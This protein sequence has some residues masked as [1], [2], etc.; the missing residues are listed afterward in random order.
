[1][2]SYFQ[3]NSNVQIN[4]YVTDI[5]NKKIFLMDVSN[6][7]SWTE[8]KSFSKHRI[9]QTTLTSIIILIAQ[10]AYKNATDGII[11]EPSTY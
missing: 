9:V 2:I 7:Y 10:N 3:I 11:F 6:Y 4:I 1:M 8:K 5:Q